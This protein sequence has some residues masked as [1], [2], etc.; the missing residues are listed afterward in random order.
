MEDRIMFEVLPEDDLA[1]HMN[2]FGDFIVTL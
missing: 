1:P 2:E